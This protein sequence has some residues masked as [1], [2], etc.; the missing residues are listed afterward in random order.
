MRAIIIGAG[1]VGSRVAEE[2]DREGW[3]L[4]VIDQDEQVIAAIE[5]RLD[6][7]TIVANGTHIPT[8][9]SAGIQEA[10]L[11]VAVTDLDEKNILSCIFAKEYG[12]PRKIARVRGV[13]ELQSLGSVVTSG[14]L[15]IDDLFDPDRV[16]VEEIV[17]FIET[18]GVSHIVDFAGG[19]V[20][21]LGTTIENDSPLAE[22]VLSELEIGSSLVVAIFRNDTMIIPKGQNRIEVGDELFLLT[23]VEAMQ[24][25]LP[26]LRREQFP[27]AK[28][29]TILSGSRISQYLAERLAT[30]AIDVT[31][32][33]PDADRCR[34]LAEQLEHALVVN[35][36]YTDEEL[37]L[38][39]GAFDTDAFVTATPEEGVNLLMALVAKQHKVLNVIAVLKRREYV[40][41]ALSVGVD[42]AIDERRVLADTI[43]KLVRRGNILSVATLLD[44][45]AEALEMEVIPTSKCLDRPLSK[46][47]IPRGAIVAA[48]AR[49]QDVLIPH[50]NSVLKSGD[51]VIFFALPKAVRAID[52]LFAG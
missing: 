24:D 37:L 39:E 52:E 16:L 46:M 31:I 10:D 7:Q 3:D 38:N 6:V 9:E 40:P 30:M 51:R 21:F 12:V 20:K 43:L 4:V 42:I 13:T 11:L 35:G 41:L 8:L 49:G 22:K 2:L 44:N 32:V 45:K 15:G 27:E 23:R 14:K 26:L 34:N 33:E 47:R 28:K 1:G 29:V 48:I 18:P 36:D 17:R 5:E 19:Q 50:G 25:L